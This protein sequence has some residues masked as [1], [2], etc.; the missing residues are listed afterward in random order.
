MPASFRTP[1]GLSSATPTWPASSPSPGS[2]A[3]LESAEHEMLRSLGLSVHMDWQGQTLTIPARRGV[4]RLP[5]VGPLRGRPDHPDDGSRTS[6]VVDHLRVQVL[7]QGGGDCP[8]AADVRLLPRDGDHQWNRS[9]SPTASARSSKRRPVEYNDEARSPHF[10]RRSRVM[11]ARLL[12]CVAAACCCRPPSAP[13]DTKTPDADKG[14][15]A[16]NDQLNP[17]QGRGRPGDAGQGGGAGQ[18]VPEVRL[19]HAH[20]RQYPIARAMPEPP[21]VRQHLR[22]SADGKLTLLNEPKALE[23][24]FKDNVGPTKELDPAK[25]AARAWLKLSP[26]LQQDGFFKFAIMD[27]STKAELVQDR[28]SASGKVVVMQAGNGEINAKLSFADG[29]LSR[30]RR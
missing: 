10:M 17:V 14:K 1:A 25:D 24:F 16:V 20:Y 26:E 22:Y 23:K 15:Q 13:D 28:V 18:G 4:L 5:P 7:P 30:S 2:S 9:R 29:K 8:R 19:L 27:D 6:P 11:R 12:F 3:S 21:E